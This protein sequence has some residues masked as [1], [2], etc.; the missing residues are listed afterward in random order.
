MSA[1]IMWLGQA[2]FLLKTENGS[3]AVD[4]FFGE[5]KGNSER[6][7]PPFLEKKSVY[8]DL[9][10][11]THAHWD[12]FDPVTYEDY[13]IPKAIVG[14]GTCMK[15]LAQSGLSIEGIQL[16]RGQQLDRCGFHVTATTA[17][18]DVDSVGYLIETDGRRLY[19][20]GDALFTTKTIVPNVGIA[21]DAAFVCIN[22]K[23]GNMN[24]MEAASYCRILGARVGVPTHYDLIRHNTENP[25]EF[26]DALAR[27]APGIRSF[28]ME[29]GKEYQI[30]E[31]L[32]E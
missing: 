28:V 22:G 2:G 17:D 7:Y 20:S 15:A 12:H 4:P 19:F 29:R 16:D 27:V 13:V 21:P 11:T 3:H 32:A 18:H 25:K 23:L 26:T 30:E 1:T 31:I 5:A 8:V 10:L 6:I 9:V 24:Y 14:P